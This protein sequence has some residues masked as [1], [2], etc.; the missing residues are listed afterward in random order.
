MKALLSVCLC[1][2]LLVAV[3]GIGKISQGYYF[4]ALAVVNHFSAFPTFPN[5][6]WG[7]DFIGSAA[8]RLGYGGQFFSWFGGFDPWVKG[9]PV[10][11]DKSVIERMVMVL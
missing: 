8:A 6:D 9:T 4:S 10:Y 1:L 3:P 7:G 5:L 2:F 11:R